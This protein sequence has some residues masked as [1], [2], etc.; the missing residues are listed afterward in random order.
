MRSGDR[1]INKK[2][3]SNC[4]LA[5]VSHLLPRNHSCECVQSLRMHPVRVACFVIYSA[6]SSMILFSSEIFV[7]LLLWFRHLLVTIS[8][9]IVFNRDIN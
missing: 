8:S 2:L 4:D 5:H 9:V 6:Y 3:C 7:V 1:Y